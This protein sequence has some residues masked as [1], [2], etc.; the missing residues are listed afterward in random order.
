MYVQRE[1]V[2]FSSLGLGNEVENDLTE[3]RVRILSGIWRRFTEE[4]VERTVEEF[5]SWL[6]GKES[7]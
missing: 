3:S 7:G 6:R 5:L 2:M 4:Q 1:A